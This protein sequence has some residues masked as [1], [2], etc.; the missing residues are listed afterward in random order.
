MDERARELLRLTLKK[1]RSNLPL[2]FV[3]DSS[4]IICKKIT[5]L[6]PYQ[7][8]NNLALYYSQKGEVN[9]YSLLEVSEGSHK[10]CYLPCITENK[11]LIFCRADLKE[12]LHVNRFGIY[13]PQNKS[14][15]D[16]S[17]LEL[18][19]IPMLAFDEY[20][21][22]LGMGGGYYDRCLEK[23]NKALLIGVAYE[24]QKI[25]YIPQQPWDVPMDVI[26]TEKNTYWIKQ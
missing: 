23:N 26:I 7:S 24:F 21:T 22:R 3:E 18:I 13:E 19:C 12:P 4:K 10:S 16:L 8:A 25:Q 2:S 14:E 11:S 6:G 1:V 17:L 9:L 15:I 5:A 20:G